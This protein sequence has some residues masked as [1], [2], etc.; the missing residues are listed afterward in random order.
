MG[1]LKR[2]R[3]KVKG[4]SK[5]SAYPDQNE[6]RYDG[7]ATD[8]TK[9]LP[10]AILRHVF[11][12]VCPHSLDE[13]L[14]A[15]EESVAVNDCMLCD[16]RDLAHC[17]LVCRRW[18]SGAQDLLYQHVR[19]DAVHYCDLEVLLA[20]KRKKSSWL[21]HNAE[22]IDAPRT[23]LLLFM[24][25]VREPNDLGRLVLSLRMP[26]MTRET[27]K[28][29][30]ART[31]SV[32]PNLRYVDLP[33]GVFTDDASSHMLKLELMARCPDL[34]RMKYIHG[35][36]G[37]FSAIPQKQP[38]A[39]IEVLELSKLSVEPTLL[40][41]ALSSFSRLQDL[42]LED[43]HWLEDRMF[44]PMPSSPQFPPLQ[45]LTLEATPQITTTGLTAYLSSPQNSHA[46]KHLS[47]FNTGILPQEL[48]E[49]LTRATS[50]ETL[51]I[52]HQVTRALPTETVPLLSSKS[53]T[54]LHYEITSESGPYG[55]QPISSSYYTHLM[56]S[57]LAGNLPALKVLYVRDAHF[58]ESLMLAPPPRLGG[59]GGPRPRGGGFNQML[60][61]YSKG[62][63]ETEWNFTNYEPLAGSGR[64]TSMA[65]P[66]SVHGAQL[67]PSWGE[68][69]RE[70]VF[71]GNGVDGFLAVPSDQR[72]KSSGGWSQTGSRRDLWR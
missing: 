5:K 43:M 4:K 37:S 1:F 32:L 51:S 46:L 71:M 45:R 61:V 2:L 58:S 25:T 35:S 14:T 50:L 26:Y 70:S 49:I 11:A 9:R 33:V 21:N 24:R 65:R 34:R 42:K 7:R 10:P 57:L 67:G 40:C 47:L 72:P 8:Y 20:A 18:C 3:L 69:A 66:V 55:A 63:D 19:I 52:I 48:H 23:R 68:N 27:S 62:E 22:P 30:L 53:L 31:V 39:N 60:A 38:W 28:N 59:E 15:S 13:S 44:E 64:P 41:Q 16:M 17:A 36:E 6:G 12:Q 54:L 29:E 56:S